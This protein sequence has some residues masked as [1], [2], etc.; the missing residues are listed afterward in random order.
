MT[1]VILTF[2]C[3]EIEDNYSVT[4]G[5]TPQDLLE[6]AEIIVLVRKYAEALDRALENSDKTV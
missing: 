3:S 1:Y 5:S 4:T 2:S 6:A